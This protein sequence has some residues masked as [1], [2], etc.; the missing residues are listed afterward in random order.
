MKYENIIF[1]QG[2]EAEKVL[3]MVLNQGERK[4]LEHLKQWDNGE[5]PV[6][7]CEGMPWGTKDR[8]Y[9]NESYVMSYN[10]D[11]GHIGLAKIPKE[12]KKKLILALEQLIKLT[13]S[14][15]H[16]LELLEEEEIVIIHYN[17]GYSKRVNI[18]ADSGIAIVEDVVS[19]LI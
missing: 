9:R 10:M 12:D 7:T 16:D 18:A 19:K 17:N 4:A 11:L 8:I 3:E 5:S 1:L 14:E 15:V 6:E 2:S 13:R